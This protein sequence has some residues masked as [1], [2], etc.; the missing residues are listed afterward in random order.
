MDA[1]ASTGYGPKAAL[2][3]LVPLGVLGLR[4]LPLIMLAIVVKLATLYLLYQQTVV[5]QKWIWGLLCL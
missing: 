1:L 2:T 3:I 4:Y 5:F